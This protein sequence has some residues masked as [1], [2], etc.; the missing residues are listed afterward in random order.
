MRHDGIA[1]LPESYFSSGF[2]ESFRAC[3][4]FFS[5]CANQGSKSEISIQSS[6]PGIQRRAKVL[7]LTPKTNSS[8]NHVARNH[9]GLDMTSNEIVSLRE[10]LACKAAFPRSSNYD[11]QWL[12]GNYMGPHVLWLAEWLTT[13][14]KLEPRMRVLDLGC[15]RAL[16][17]I[18]LAKEFGVSVWAADLWTKPA[19][20]WKRIQQ[21]ELTDRVFPLLVEAH[22]M[23]FA[24]GFF[25]AIVSFD[26]FHYFGT[27][28]LYM[29][30]CKQ[31]IRTGGRLGIASP[32]VNE[33][34]TAGVPGHLRPYWEWEFCSFHS[35]DWW[36]NHWE[37]T[38]LVEVE[39]ADSM[40]QGAKLWREWNE[41]CAE[42]GPPNWREAVAHEAEMLEVDA[43]RTLGF[44]RAI[45][46]T[47]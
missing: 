33:E 25:D 32:G 39:V 7:P 31:F 14:M 35:P 8:Y 9:T 2:F 29:G 5:R 4:C 12:M 27:D 43:E 26:A 1:V 13:G 44:T 19:E 38:G 3:S 22:T 17:S 42:L 10:R 24:N 40:P 11:P 41:L 21:A 36:R 6:I 23:P 47:K 30:Y 20:N 34:L 37:K 18:F 16:S 28:D 45:A 15:G 46:R